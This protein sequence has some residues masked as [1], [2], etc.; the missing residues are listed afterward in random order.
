MNAVSPISVEPPRKN[1]MLD[2]HNI[3]AGIVHTL[4]GITY[5]LTVA[6]SISM[7]VLIQYGTLL[8]IAAQLT[9]WVFRIV[10]LVGHWWRKRRR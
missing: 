3:T 1:R 6:K 10:D 4:P 2:G 5:L 7:P 9:Y 8:V